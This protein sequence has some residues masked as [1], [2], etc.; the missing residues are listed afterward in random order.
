MK[1]VTMKPRSRSGAPRPT[2]VSRPSARAVSVDM[3]TPHPDAAPL[4][5]LISTNAVAGAAIP[6]IPARTGI[7]NRLRCRRSPRSSCRR[8][9]TPTTRK[10]NVIN[11]RLTQ[12]RSDIS[13]WTLPTPTRA[14]SFQI[15]S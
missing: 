13:I 4:R 15:V 5:R 3:A 7:T 12:S 6:T 2:S 14:G 10:K 1:T 11:P 8:A 9:S